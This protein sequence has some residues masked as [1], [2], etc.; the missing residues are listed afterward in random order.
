MGTASTLEREIA[1]PASEAL[2]ASRE[3]SSDD[4]DRGTEIHA[5][6]KHAATMPL[7]EALAA[8]PKSLRELCASIE[9]GKIHGGLTNVRSE[10]SYGIRLGHEHAEVVGV[11]IDRRYPTDRGEEWLFG[12]NDVEGERFD[13]L[14]DTGDVKTGNDV[15][16]AADN[17]QAQ[18]A[19]RAIQLV[20]GEDEVAS[21]IIYVRPSGYVHIDWHVFTRL[22]LETFEDR[23][24]EARASVRQARADYAAG[25][26]LTVSPGD[27]CKYCP[28]IA[29]CPAKMSLARAM[30]GELAELDQAIRI[31][32]S[33]GV[34]RLVSQLSPEQAGQAVRK[35]AEVKDLHDRIKG[36]LQL[37][38]G[39]T[40][41]P[42]G[43]GKEYRPITFAK[44][45]FSREK[46]LALLEA[47]GA[48]PEEIA[49]L[50]V[51][52]MET[53]FRVLKARGFR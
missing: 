25:K 21:R 47:K 33:E 4:A 39:R 51:P 7:H 37:Y 1:C 44:S 41:L 32:K 17:P 36:A 24:I 50:S 22:E 13:G 46:A 16:A 15:T 11:D 14:L 31:D 42:V 9:L 27:H 48:T 30:V 43:D 12:S 52:H 38:A 2:P 5:F 28:A 8:V 10:V 29:S 49:A 53:Q 40:P 3:A 26:P 35:L 18:F 45:G 6:I 23:A 34:G 20:T 19:A